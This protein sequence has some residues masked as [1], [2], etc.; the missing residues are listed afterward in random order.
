MSEQLNELTPY[1][2]EIP[3]WLKLKIK[4]LPSRKASHIVREMIIN[5][6]KY[7]DNSVPLPDYLDTKKMIREQNK[8][9]L[10]FIERVSR[11]QKLFEDGNL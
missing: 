6:F 1:H 9:F 10:E 8:E 11:Q 2:I 7:R 5:G 4:E 3:V